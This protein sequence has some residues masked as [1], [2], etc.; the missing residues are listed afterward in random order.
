MPLDFSNK[1]TVFTRA[2]RVWGWRKPQKNESF[3]A[4]R[5]AF[6]EYVRYSDPEEADALAAGAVFTKWDVVKT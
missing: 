2:V 1:E 4:Y 6:A 3:E 5:A